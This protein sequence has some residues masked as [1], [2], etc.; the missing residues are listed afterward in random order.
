MNA[1]LI[2]FLFP[3]SCVT[4]IFLSSARANSNGSI[5]MPMTPCKSH[6]SLESSPPSSSSSE[7]SRS[8]IPE[9]IS[10]PPCRKGRKSRDQLV[11][12]ATELVK[13]D[14][15]PKNW[16]RTPSPKDLK[17]DRN[18]V[19]TVRRRPTPLRNREM[20]RK[21]NQIESHPSR[22]YPSELLDEY[23]AAMYQWMCFI[24]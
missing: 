7:S 24:E 19:K 8:S 11:R 6:A 23:L 16:N 13:M 3:G 5:F 20:K 2:A 21:S 9:L 14:G 4:F 10:V 17:Q 22:R 1:P 18:M 12:Y 15:T